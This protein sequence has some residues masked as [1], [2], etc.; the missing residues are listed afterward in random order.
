MEL[1]RRL[2]TEADKA[3][4]QAASKQAY[5]DVV[6]RQFGV[7]DVEAEE[8]SFNGKWQ[9]AAFYVIERAGEAIGAICTTDEH[10][11]VRLNEVFLVPG[12]QGRGLGS[13]L[14]QQELCR[15]RGVCKPLR[16]R[17]LKHNRARVLY[18]RLGFS[19][20]GETETQF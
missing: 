13:Q 5:E 20:C 4:V 10:D 11:H 8:R 19:V 6:V 2:A 18:E 7:W 12:H 16:L 14:V 1:T 17:V 3:F 9:R 15:A